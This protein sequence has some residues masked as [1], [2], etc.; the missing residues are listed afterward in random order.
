MNLVELREEFRRKICDEI[1]IEDQGLQRYIVYT[2]FMFDDGDH[3]VVVLK[4]E[5][6]DRW[7]LT[8]EGHTFMHI[9]YDNLD[10]SHGTR[11]S[12]VDQTLLSFAMVNDSGEIRLDVPEGAF[13]DALFSFLQGL[14][15]ITD[16]RFLTRERAKSTFMEDFRQLVSEKIPGQRLTLDYTDPEHDQKQFYPVD[17]RVNG[18]VRPLFIFAV[19]NDL[20]CSAAHTTILQFEKWG[21]RFNSMAIF[22]DQTQ[23]NRSILARFSDAVGKQFSDLGDRNRIGNYLDEVLNSFSG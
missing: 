5:S 22:E 6:N 7:I 18:T 4:R 16:I 14:T 3:F 21:R 17:C 15:K 23:I 9:S 12:I 8:D 13:G 10:V 20:K 1:D 11:R 2:P 19:S